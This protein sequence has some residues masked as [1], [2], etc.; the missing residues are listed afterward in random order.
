MNSYPHPF[1]SLL[2]LYAILFDLGS[3]TS[4]HLDVKAFFFAISPCNTLSILT[5]H[6]TQPSTFEQ[7]DEHFEVIYKIRLY[8]IIFASGFVCLFGFV[9][10]HSEAVLAIEGLEK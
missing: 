9:H 4:R 5:I 10:V 7:Y 1:N 2:L 8:Y 6:S 3:W